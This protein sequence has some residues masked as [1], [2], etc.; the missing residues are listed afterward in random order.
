MKKLMITML[1]RALLHYTLLVVMLNND[2]DDVALTVFQ[3]KH[4]NFIIL[5]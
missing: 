2:G 3:G 4:I 5:V 1:I